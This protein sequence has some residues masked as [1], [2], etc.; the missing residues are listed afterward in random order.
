ML[1]LSSKNVHLMYKIIFLDSLLKGLQE[2]STS[3][4]IVSLEIGLNCVISD[5]KQGH[6]I[7]KL[8]TRDF[9]VLSYPRTEH[10]TAYVDS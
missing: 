1:L 8:R 3:K 2:F 7:W 10:K 4:Q 6:I 9:R 5:Y